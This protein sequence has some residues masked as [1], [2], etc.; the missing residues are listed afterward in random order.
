[1]DD[2][3]VRRSSRG[4][5][6][7]AAVLALGLIGSLLFLVVQLSRWLWNLVAT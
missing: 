6:V 3:R 5:I 2:R 7:V 4:L 1:M